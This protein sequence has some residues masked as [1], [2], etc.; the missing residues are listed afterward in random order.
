MKYNILFVI[1]TSIAVILLF[2]GLYDY[3]FCP[4]LQMKFEENESKGTVVSFLPVDSKAYRSGIHILDTVIAVNGREFINKYDMKSNIIYDMNIGDIAVL[5]ILRNG[6]TKDVP[7]VLETRKKRYEIVF[8]AF[9][10]IVLLLS[11]VFFYITFPGRDKYGFWIYC[12]YILLSILYLYTYVSFE[13]PY[14]YIFLIF[15]GSFAAGFPLF[16][17]IKLI[18]R[19]TREKLILIPLL[20]SSAVFIVWSIYYL[21]WVGDFSHVR[22]EQL[23]YAIRWTQ[24]ILGIETLTG[25]ALLIYGIY[26]RMRK[27]SHQYI[28]FIVFILFVGFIPYLVLYAFPVAV[29]MKEIIS[30]DLSLLFAIVPL[31]AILI[32]NNFIY[33]KEHFVS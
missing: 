6:D 29:G 21:L 11:S 28:P 20:L 4:E 19:N 30:I 27:K 17:G 9:I 25:M 16:M 5:T 10:V 3:L 2:A 22:M 18:F 7:V 13:K 24:F 26:L 1:V 33:E 32:Y 31:L 8:S 12:F 23:N 15:S 14:L